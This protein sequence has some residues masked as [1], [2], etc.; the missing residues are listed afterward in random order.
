MF[1]LLIILNIILRLPSTPHELGWD[2][3]AIHTTANTVSTFGHAKWWLNFSSVFGFYPY[4]YASAVPFLLSGMSQ[5]ALMEMEQ[6]ILLFCILIGLLSAL[7]AYLM[8]NSIFEDQLFAFIVAL[9]YSTSSGILYF[10]TWTVSTRGLF[11]VLLPLF[12]YLLLKSRQSKKYLLLLPPFYVYLAAI[13]HLFYFLA[14]PIIALLLS[15]FIFRTKIVD[16]FEDIHPSFQSFLVIVFFVLMLIF[17]IFVP[18]F[19]GSDP[20]PELINTQILE[21][22]R[23]TGV[24]ILIFAGSLFYLIFKKKKTY[25][26][27]FILISLIGFTPFFYVANYGK[28]FFL[29]L[30][31]IM[32]GIGLMNVIFVFLKRSDRSLTVVLS[33]L[34]LAGLVFSCY[35]QFINYLENTDDRYMNEET[36]QVSVWMKESIEGP[37]FAGERYFG[38]RV[39]SIA[40]VP[41]LTGQGFNDI[42]YGF[43]DPD[44]LEI[45]KVHSVFSPYFYLYD[46]YKE[47]NSSSSWKLWAIQTTSFTTPNSYAQRI[48]KHYGFSH[49]VNNRDYPSTFARSIEATEPKLY[50]SGTM[51]VWMLSEIP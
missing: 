48:I 36:Y 50:D 30:A 23:F 44:S 46:P 39:L 24:L 27:W 29:S 38:I 34:I 8:A 1:V 11:I 16:Y 51:N 6:T 3:F 47:A 41:M 33:I 15:E 43:V 26:E 31:F 22:L 42:S 10:T 25:G 12:Y 21:Y 9:L 17:P 20:L 28:W 14:I 2:S 49:F 19:I 5:L 4:S 18:G 37:A 13:H 7:T 35:F 32:I 40:E 45:T